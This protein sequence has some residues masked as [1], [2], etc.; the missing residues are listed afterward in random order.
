MK[1][2]K[3]MKVTTEAENILDMAE[4]NNGD[5]TIMIASIDL[6]QEVDENHKTLYL[7]TVYLSEWYNC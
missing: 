7:Y 1:A 5:H 4:T 2:L 6:D 3:K